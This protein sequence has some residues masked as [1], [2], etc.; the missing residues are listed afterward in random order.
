M[1]DNYE[2]DSNQNPSSAGGWQAGPEQHPETAWT[3]PGQDL[4]GWSSP[5]PPAQY[6]TTSGWQQTPSG[7]PNTPGSGGWGGT[8]SPDG[9]PPKKRRKGFVVFGALVGSVMAIGLVVLAGFGAYNLANGGIGTVETMPSEPSSSVPEGSHLTLKD[10][11]R[12][13]AVER[14][15]GKL[16]TEEIVELVEPS[17]VAITTY[18]NFQSLQA[19]GMGS[20]IIIREDG[21]IVTNAHV[22]ENAL[23]ITVQMNEG[24]PLEARLVAADAKS[25]LAVIRVDSTGLP[26]AEFGNSDQVKVG[27][28]VLAI[29]NPQS[30]NFYGSVTQGIVS[31]LN[32]QVTAYSQ[33]G[34]SQ[35]RYNNLIQT[36][37]AINPGNS[38]G[39]LVNSYGQVIGINSAKSG[40]GAE[41]M[42]F[43]IPANEVQKIVDDL[44]NYQRVTGRVRLGITAS[45]VDIVMARNYNV[46]SGVL[47]QSTE[48]NSDISKKGV[49]PNDIITKINGKEV[50]GLEVI[51]QELEGLNPGDT[52][53][54][55]V[56]RV[57][58][59]SNGN[60][61]FFNVTVAVI[62]DS[63]SITTETNQQEQQ[64]PENGS[65][66]YSDP[67]QDIEDFFNRFF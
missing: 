52:V 62:E 60:G 57:P 38:G 44:I 63:T 49:I 27:E 17:V 8:P 46:P 15:D 5:K 3:T 39:A 59:R 2:N 67:Y 20:G 16:T 1:Y 24:E 30:M 21:Y 58:N 19:T 43:A 47:V 33:D 18:S 36:D 13:E 11:P 64:K 45:V 4:G 37:A 9:K 6:S 23:S 41:G 10:V 7:P 14:V 50:T 55:E 12:N 32:R 56:Y 51:E 54:L 22:V 31:G 42:G 66:G 40:G 25:D 29:G 53:E 48:Q 61:R 28:T 65:N 35:T 34:R 26:A